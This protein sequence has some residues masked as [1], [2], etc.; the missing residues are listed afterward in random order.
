MS[1]CCECCLLSGRGLCDGPITRPEESCR[2]WCVIVWDIEN[3]R[4][5]EG[6]KTHNG[7]VMPE[8]MY[9]LFKLI[10]MISTVWRVL[11]VVFYYEI[12]ILTV[13]LM[14]SPVLSDKQS[15]PL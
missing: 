10:L 8:K 15:C 2:L 12:G 1:L 4:N 3:L 13:L 9:N 11:P 6:Y 14:K 5:E 7:V